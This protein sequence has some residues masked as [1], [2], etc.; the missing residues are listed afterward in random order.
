MDFHII[1]DVLLPHPLFLH[2]FLVLGLFHLFHQ[3]ILIRL[4]VL[5]TL[6][7]FLLSDVLELIGWLH[8]Y[9]LLFLWTIGRCRA[10]KSITKFPLVQSLLVRQ[11]SLIG[12]YQVD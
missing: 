1:F 11:V 4:F 2:L 10:C 6:V 12:S 7:E 9:D 5:F 3:L 8:M